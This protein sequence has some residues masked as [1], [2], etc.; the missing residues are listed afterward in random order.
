[1]KGRPLLFGPQ[2][3]QWQK[4]ESST[5]IHITP[6]YAHISVVTPLTRISAESAKDGDQSA[7]SYYM[8]K[9]D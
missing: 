7:R 4:L 3:I 6:G 5:S 8:R 1:M 2:I 9:A